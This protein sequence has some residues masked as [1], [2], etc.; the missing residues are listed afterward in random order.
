MSVEGDIGAREIL[1]KNPDSILA[2]DISNSQIFLDVD[3]P[4]DI[5]ALQSQLN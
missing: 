1:L 2:V 3:T 4:A 5:E